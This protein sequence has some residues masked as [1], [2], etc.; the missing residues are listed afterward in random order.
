VRTRIGRVAGVAGL[1]AVLAV[2]VAGCSKSV[3]GTALAGA[4]IATQ[5]TTTGGDLPTSDQTSGSAPTSTG[6]GDL[7][8]KAQQTCG[9]LPKDAVTQS[10]GVSDV[11]ITA[12]GGTTLS[13]G[14]QQ[15]TCVITGQ[16]AFGASVVVQDYPSSSIKTPQQYAQIMGQQYKVTPITVDGADV[17]GTFVQPASGKQVD[18]A[19]AATTDN[20]TVLVLLAGVPDAPG[21]G[22]KLIAFLKAL[23]K[24]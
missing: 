14:V 7:D 23:V 16:P 8:Q 5:T 15:I 18:E 11:Q 10:F 4:T 2:G 13:G 12:G 17:A 21:V 9:Q 22:P 6:G 24:D 20:G 3:Q 19:Y 1:A